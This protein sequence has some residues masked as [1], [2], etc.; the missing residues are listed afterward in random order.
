MSHSCDADLPA[1][2]RNRRADRCCRGWNCK[3]NCQQV[4]KLSSQKIQW[5]L[6]LVSSFL[7]CK[8]GISRKSVRCR[9][10]DSHRRLL[11]DNLFKSGD[12]HC[13]DTWATASVRVFEVL[14]M[15][16]V[17]LEAWDGLQRTLCNAHFLCGKMQF[18][19]LA[20]VR[21]DLQ[22]A[23]ETCRNAACRTGT[24]SCMHI[25]LHVIS[26]FAVRVT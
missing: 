14:P 21:N 22:Q 2:S 25:S 16:L 23:L 10:I 8:C 11:A 7:P 5:L 4:C 24:L 26:L 6:H 12:A 20:S 15:E 18:C 13:D 9:T 19:G 17:R 1:G 3:P